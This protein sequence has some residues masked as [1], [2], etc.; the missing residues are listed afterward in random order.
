LIRL[1]IN[2]WKN[3]FIGE[4]VLITQLTFLGIVE[5]QTFHRI[6]IL[7]RAWWLLNLG[8]KIN[9][10]ILFFVKVFA[11][12]FLLAALFKRILTEKCIFVKALE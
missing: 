12:M 10:F 11:L 3:G 4:L 5:N 1:H 8:K 2:V 9:F 6:Q 7:L